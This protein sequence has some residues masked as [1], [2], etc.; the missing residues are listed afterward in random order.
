M[1]TGFASNQAGCYQICVKG[2]LTPSW[3]EWF[4]GFAITRIDGDSLLT[5]KVPDQAALHGIIAKIRD[6]GLTLV[7]IQTMEKGKE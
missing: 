7:F 3:S 1:E 5:G 6:M 2:V 4:D